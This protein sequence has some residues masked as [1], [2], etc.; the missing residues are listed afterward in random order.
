MAK[1]YSA[2]DLAK[3]VFVITAAGIVVWV[4]AAFYFVILKQ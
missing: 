3:R 1:A 4:A 2:E